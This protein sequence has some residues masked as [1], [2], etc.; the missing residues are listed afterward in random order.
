MN[1]RCLYCY[2]PLEKNETDFHEKCC[3]NFFGVPL[4][5]SLD[6]DKKGL[7]KMAKEIIIR[8]I[9]VTGVQPKLSLTIEKT[10]GDKKK[11]RLTIVGAMGGNF[12]LK[13]SSENF[14]SLPENEDL[15]MHLSQLLGIKTAEHSLIR[16]KSGELA[17]ITKRFDRL[18]DEKFHCEDLCQLTESLTEQKYKGSME[19]VGKTIKKYSSYPMLDV[20]SFFEIALFSFLTGNADMHMKNFSILKDSKNN[21]MLAPCYD[22]LS[23]KLA[24]PEDKE[25][26]A[27]T[28]NGRKNKITKS[29]FDLFGKNLGLDEKQMG[30]VYEKIANKKNALMAFVRIS[31]LPEKT[32]SEYSDLLKRRIKMF[33]K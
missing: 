7:E 11:S 4:P 28:I 27:L 20:L 10:P 30:S 17:Y 13:P 33:A 31:F 21:Y 18:N 8:S 9:A 6:L 22:L 2:L 1:K 15:T 24:N 5:P 12:I 29:D 16:I 32:K 14:P 19:K 25:E 23:T 26:M 3:V